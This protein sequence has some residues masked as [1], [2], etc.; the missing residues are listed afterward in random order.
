MGMYVCVYMCICVHTVYTYMCL[1]YSKTISM[2]HKLNLLVLCIGTP[3]VFELIVQTK[4]MYMYIHIRMYVYNYL[5]SLK[6]LTL[7]LLKN[8]FGII[9]DFG[10]DLV[11]ISYPEGCENHPVQ[12]GDSC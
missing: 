2:T 5:D 1:Y 11:T 10:R 4:L 7:A 12:F 9:L 6:I 8:Y 3:A